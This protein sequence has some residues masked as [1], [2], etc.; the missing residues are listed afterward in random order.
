M[1]RAVIFYI[2]SRF[3]TLTVY[4]EPKDIDIEREKTHS[5]HSWEAS[6]LSVLYAV[7]PILISHY[8]TKDIR[9]FD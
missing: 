8:S 5:L 2:Y 7:I 9:F 3:C 4:T 1:L 6:H